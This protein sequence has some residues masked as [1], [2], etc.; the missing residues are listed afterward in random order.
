MK[1][2]SN[3]GGILQKTIQMVKK[4]ITAHPTTELGAARTGTIPTAAV[5]VVSPLP[6]LPPLLPLL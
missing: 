2:L 3:S 1:S 6:L 5:F 4:R